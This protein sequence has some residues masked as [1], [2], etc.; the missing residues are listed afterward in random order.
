MTRNQLQKHAAWLPVF[1]G[2][3]VL[4]TVCSSEQPQSTPVPTF[5]KATREPTATVTPVRPIP[6]PQPPPVREVSQILYAGTE[7]THVTSFKLK[8]KASEFRPDTSGKFVVLITPETDQPYYLGIFN[9]NAVLGDIFVLSDPLTEVSVE[10][11]YRHACRESP[12]KLC[13]WYEI[14]II[15]LQNR[16][17]FEDEN[18]GRREDLLK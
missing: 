6:T 7:I 18:L 9:Y 4:G 15:M 3:V 1:F 13:D 17:L 8:D 2:L 16:L 12:Y 14:R 5:V 10:D 11:Q